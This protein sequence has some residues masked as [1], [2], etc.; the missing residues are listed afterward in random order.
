[1]NSFVRINSIVGFV[2][3]IA[4]AIIY[5]LTMEPTLSFWDCGEFIAA[6]FKLEVGHQPGA[7]LYLLI[8]R[9]FS[10][11]ALGNTAKVA[12][13]IN[14]SSVLASAATVMFLFW[15]ITALAK[16]TVA[17]ITTS[18]QIW[19]IMAAGTV[20][21][22]AYA[23][24]DTFWFSAV[25]AEVYALSALF[26]AVTFWAI[27]KWEENMNDK[28]LI[29]IAFLTGLSI[30]VH[31]L[32]L[33][34]IPILVL[35]YYFRKTA[36]ATW[37]G[38]LKAFLIGCLIL[39]IVQF[40][41]IQY[42]VLWAAKL[43]LLFVNSLG[44]GFGSGAITFILLVIAAIA[45][46]I[47]Y[48]IKHQKYYYNLGLLCLAFVLFGFSAYF[49]IIIRA[50]AKPN[51]NLSNPDQPFSL[52]GYLGRTNYGSTPL[53]YGQT[54]NAERTDIKETGNEYRKAASKYE[55]SGKT[56][57]PVYDKNMLFPR[58]YSDKP[59]HQQFYQQWMGLQPGETP[60]F[61][62]NLR[63]F[64]SYQLGFMYWRYF[65]WNFVGRQNDVQGQGS[66]D[67]GNWL[68]GIKAL[69]AARL[70]SQT[71]LPE[72][73]TKNPGRNI[74]YGLPLILGLIGM[75][76]LYRKNKKVSIIIAGLFLVTGM[77]IIVYLNQDPLQVRERDYVY[78]G[79]F[80]AFCIWIGFGM[81]AFKNLLT[82]YTN[83]KY[84]LITAT[85]VTFVAV[86]LL[87]AVQGWDDHNRSNKT[88]ALDWAKNYLNSCAPN[89]IL[90]TNADNDTYPLWYAQEVEGIRTDVRVVNYQ[91][92][93]DDAYINQMKKQSYKS[94]PLPISMN[95]EQYKK[96]V[97]DYLP[98]VDYGLMDSVELSD[99]LAVLTSDNQQDKVQMMDG[100]Y[101]N[102]L[103]TKKLKLTI[104]KQQLVKTKTI[105]PE[106]INKVA[107][108]MEW[109]L[110]G[111]GARKTELAMLDIIRTNNWE[112]P[113][114]FASKVSNDTYLGMEKYLYL[115]GYAHRLLPYERN[116]DDKRNIDEVTNT[117][118]LYNNIINKLD[119]KGFKTAKYLDPETRRILRAT[120]DLNNTLAKNLI[121]EGK[122]GMALK[123]VEKSLRELPMQNYHI[124]DTLDKVNL[125]QNLYALNATKE[126]N[127]LTIKTTKFVDQE[128]QY[129]LTLNNK[130]QSAYVNDVEIGMY[131]LSILEK[132]TNSYGQEKINQD[133]KTQLK[134]LETKFRASFNG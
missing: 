83:P 34:V 73:I 74:F 32:N 131:V 128:L 50:D 45:Y 49:A 41:V 16:K 118:V 84:S 28:W 14:M 68:S 95:E 43:D 29:F 20:G 18:N 122:Q 9:L 85:L 4:S 108:H 111:N 6:A 64:A 56:Y 97:R 10:L 69:D 27:L 92:L 48:T 87:M 81:L 133:V 89:A 79:S 42:F 115:E 104:N 134:Q 80:Y 54:F 63:F 99:L 125:I 132:I 5:G 51:I 30:G 77:A 88:T 46:G 24:S 21:A 36:K 15:T 70:G 57:E 94:A 98:Y 113:I 25:E 119:F 33:L 26:T 71:N 40:A 8:G 129:I 121:A 66:I 31:L 35:V 106:D 93:S 100:T 60:T 123:V 13:W 39:A 72:T 38:T 59:H 107:D 76:Y 67:N 114:Y 11:L 112:R 12:Y 91:F 2:V 127:D 116:S 17:S 65:L 53:L 120:I 3:F 82:K 44:L 124:Q 61:A 103:P 1:M 78:V 58:M 101:E 19:S 22:M 7:P 37:Q 126:A 102:F 47:F 55:L 75:I 117:E 23:F 96:G 62:Q 130:F 52:Y 109:E 86:P 90:F 105:A 110:K